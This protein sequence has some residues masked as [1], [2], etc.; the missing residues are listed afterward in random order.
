MKAEQDAQ[1]KIKG[2]WLY[3]FT[4][5]L[6][7]LW[8]ET[9]KS[10]GKVW[11]VIKKIINSCCYQFYMSRRLLAFWFPCKVDDLVTKTVPEV[12][13]HRAAR[14][15][16]YEADHLWSNPAGKLFAS[17]ATSGQETCSCFQW[18]CVWRLLAFVTTQP[19]M[20]SNPTTAQGET[21]AERLIPPWSIMKQ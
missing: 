16:G 7:S 15:T 13:G 18:T 21:P 5:K 4:S 10:S 2:I 9:F 20:G 11:Y 17:V 6:S 19:I 1:P 14:P 8:H 12:G 3:A